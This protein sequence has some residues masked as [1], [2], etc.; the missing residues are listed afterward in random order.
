M[1]PDAGLEESR[2]FR[3]DA[4]SAQLA[5][6][7]LREVLA[8][9]PYA[10]CLAD[11][12]IA[13]GEI[14]TNVI[15]HAHTDYTLT[16]R[17]CQ[18]R[19]RVEVRDGNALLPVHRLHDVD[20]TTGR[21]MDL[22]RQITADSGAELLAAGG[23]VVW[24]AMDV[25]PSELSLP[26]GEV[27]TRGV[28]DNAPV[29]S[30]RSVGA[31]VGA[32]AGAV[33]GAGAG[34]R[35]GA[36]AGEELL[37]GGSEAIEVVLSDVQPAL[38][39]VAIE[40]TDAI[41]RE[42]ALYWV[43]HPGDPVSRHDL[44]LAHAARANG[45]VAV[46]RHLQQSAGRLSAPVTLSVW[47]TPQE[48]EAFAV[49]RRVFASAEL[50]AQRSRLLRAPS[51][52]EAA[53]LRDWACE[54]VID[55]VAGRAARSWTDDHRSASSRNENGDRVQG[56]DANTVADS[57]KAV[58]AADA[59]NRIVAISAS[60]AAALGW[61]VEDLVGHG[62]NALVPFRLR[63]GHVAG[64]ARHLMTGESRV[65]GQL[66]QL[67]MLCADGS[68]LTCGLYITQEGTRVG[69]PVYVAVIT[70]PVT[71]VDR[72]AL[73]PPTA[74]AAH[75]VEVADLT[76]FG[77]TDMAR[78]AGVI[79]GLSDNQTSVASFAEQVCRYVQAHLEHDSGLQ[80][81]V[82]VR[83][84][85]AMSFSDLPVMDQVNAERNTTAALTDDTLCVALLASAG[86]KSAWNDR[87]ASTGSRVVPLTAESDLR[88]TPMLVALSQQLGLDVPTAIKRQR[89]ERPS[90][91]R[92]SYSHL[93]IGQPD[94]SRLVPEHGFIAEHGIRTV[95]TIGGALPMGASF[96]LTLFTDAEVDADTAEMFAML[97]ASISLGGFARPGLPFFDKGPTTAERLLALTAAEHQVARDHILTVLLEGY[98]RVAAAELQAAQYSLEQASFETQRY[99]ALAYTL[100][101]TL[102]PA[103]LPSIAGLQT[104]AFFRPSGD[105][106]EIGGDFYDLFPTSDQRWGFVLGDVSGKGAQAAA[107]TA[108]A[109]HTV[110]GA[111][112][113]AP[114]ACQVLERLDEAVSAR[115]ADGRY[116]T[117]L[118]AF[119]TARPGEVIIDLALGGHPQPLVLR[120]DGRLENVG[121]EGSALGLFPDP[122]LTQVR[123]VLTPGDL[124]VAFSDGVT[125]ARR[126]N[127]E[128]GE[129][130]LRLLLS[131]LDGLAAQ[132]VAGQIG[133][134]S[135]QFQRDALHDDVAVVVLRCG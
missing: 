106:S 110:R 131:R 44:A 4:R 128:Y 130:R 118:F 103:D 89:R 121:V 46:E 30:P 122:S 81:T 28:D 67:P 100:Q 104:G 32:V 95:L 88:R 84:H 93:L 51:V 2:H 126:G 29:P 24:F 34:P 109:R 54:Q 86:R 40:E 83:F 94:I 11:A 6:S 116:L 58:V 99:R 117:A 73:P 97:A 79:R 102:I 76:R 70:L 37:S 48:S 101:A 66:L 31:T 63:A 3:G 9:S 69:F 17:A 134:A 13:V 111:A 75:P 61:R 1:I 25:P 42:M 64:H 52:P 56:W 62:L 53:A 127:E 60:L 114:D 7:F 92:A 87:N 107:I 105:G 57:N 43:D 71:A 96:A 113:Y 112:F 27:L 50:L 15:L 8:G 26:A 59:G 77:L 22:V 120:A 133:Q 129:D 85:A 132:E 39:R 115:D 123:V 19:L 35:A 108:L 36:V 41:L 55:Q 33:A 119:V 74:M 10:G 5:R 23:K 38:W 21:G 47:V 20:A 68:E 18:D 98:E 82:L 78:M 91:C 90:D 124:L 135:L 16:L 65:L 125:E 49:L 72:P 80:Q 14:V 45:L 12:Q